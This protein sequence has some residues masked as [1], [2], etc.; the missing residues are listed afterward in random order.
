MII[1]NYLFHPKTDKS[2]CM[3][4]TNSIE[5]VM[6]AA[7]Y[8]EYH[9]GYFKTLVSPEQTGASFA[10]LEMVLPQGSEPPLHL[11]ENED[12]TFYVL[13][14]T[15]SFRI[16]DKTYI[17][18][19]GETIFAPRMVAHDFRIISSQ[20]HFL[21]LLTPGAFWGYFMEFSTASTTVPVVKTPVGPPPADFLLHL[22]NRLTSHYG[23]TLV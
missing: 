13:E 15:V 19:P 1:I 10:L 16:G 18:G 22:A 11:H 6:A 4:D 9:G 23:V 20:L 8:R 5:P 2:N 7:V 12:E 21:T 14:G 17:A 3:R